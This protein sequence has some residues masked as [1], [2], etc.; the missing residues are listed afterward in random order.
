MADQAPPPDDPHLFEDLFENAPCGYVAMTPD[1]RIARSNRLFSTWVGI[2]SAALVGR[3]FSELLNIAGRVYYE[4]HFA[5]L[6][7][8]QGSF[9][10]VALN[11]ARADGT[12]LPVLVN[13]VERRDDA[14]QPRSIWL[15]IFNAVDRRRYESELLKTREAL[16]VMTETQEVRIEEGV[17]KR[18]ELEGA[19]RQGQKMIV[20]G[21]LTAGLA[22]DFNNILT[23]VSGSFEIMERRIQQGRND[24]V[25]PY[26]QAGK[27]SVRR[28]IA[29][30]ARLLA[31]SRKQ[32]AVPVSVDINAVVAGME[33]LV[34]RTVGAKI[35]VRLHLAPGPAIS[36]L[37]VNQLESALLNLSVNARDA[38]AA[39][40]TLR[41]ETRHEAI[42]PARGSV[43]AV[44]PGDYNVL[45]V[46]DTG[47][48]MS[49]EVASHVLEPFFTTKAANE[50]TGLGLAMVFE[51]TR[52]ALGALRIDS[53][54]GEGTA[55][56]L[57]LP[58]SPGAVAHA[59][60]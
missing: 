22:H 41:I 27:D 8:M 16:R 51:F 46:E 42:D 50:G 13:A 59:S 3:R 5:P 29:L 26:V 54:L 56:I 35:E 58:A 20:V 32:D 17:A 24:E 14:G 6:L 48:G 39:G 45:R 34:K 36:T 40:G 11:I 52:Q 2:D 21:Q 1:G 38:M 10:E 44:E 28:A 33:D 37:D 47:V 7:R 43:L 60:R 30:A 49:K 55:V 25:A 57:Y 4:T 31:F 19:L 9:N 15:N 23:S 18:L 53:R 12:T